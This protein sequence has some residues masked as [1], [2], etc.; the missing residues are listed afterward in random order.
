MPMLTT[1]SHARSCR[2]FSPARAKLRRRDSSRVKIKTAM[3]SSHGTNSLA[4]KELARPPGRK[5]KLHSSKRNSRIYSLK[6]MP[7]ATLGL[8]SENCW[9]TLKPTPLKSQTQPYFRGKMLMATG[10]YHGRNFL[11][12]KARHRQTTKRKKRSETFSATWMRTTMPAYRMPSSIATSKKLQARNPLRGYG[13]AKTRTAMG[14]CRGMSFLAQREKPGRS[15]AHVT[16][17]KMP[18]S[19]NR[20]LISIC[21]PLWT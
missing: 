11:A 20:L 18:H 4:Q 3:A 16:T 1:K 5:R 12:R 2:T 21:L 15:L 9:T 8:P 14:S 19:S 7:T 10:G 17:T 13:S 6:W